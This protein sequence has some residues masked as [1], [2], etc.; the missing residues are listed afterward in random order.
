MTGGRDFTLKTCRKLSDLVWPIRVPQ[1]QAF[2]RSAHEGFQSQLASA[3]NF[4]P[5]IAIHLCN[6][7]SADWDGVVGVSADS[8]TSLVSASAWI[9]GG[10]LE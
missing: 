6:L 3:A 9:V 4:P 10:A 1:T 5:P 7:E 8:N 2:R